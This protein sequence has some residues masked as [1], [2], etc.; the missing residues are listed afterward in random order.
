[1]PRDVLKYLQSKAELIK[2]QNSALKVK[3][4]SNLYSCPPRKII[5]NQ[6][7]LRPIRKIETSGERVGTRI[8]FPLVRTRGTTLVSHA[9]RIYFLWLVLHLRVA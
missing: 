1:M 2:D 3:L 9:S 5:T 8:P 7:N 4:K 6:K